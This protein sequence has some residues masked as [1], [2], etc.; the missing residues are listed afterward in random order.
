MGQSKYSK[1]LPL[2]T[3]HTS[4]HRHMEIQTFWYTL[5]ISRISPTATV[6]FATSSSVLSIGVHKPVFS[7]DSRNKNRHDRSGDRTGQR[8]GPPVRSILDQM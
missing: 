2:A 8:M 1:L 4:H 3:M 7:Y 5:G 6:I